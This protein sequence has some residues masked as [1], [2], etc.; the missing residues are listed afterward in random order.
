MD[1]LAI[2]PSELGDVSDFEVDGIQN[3]TENDVSDEEIEADELARRM[4]K[5]KVR[6]KRIKERQQKL[7]LQQA[8]LE[9]AKSKNISD[10]ALRKKI[11][12]A[13]DGILK[14]MLKLMEVCNARGFVYGIIPDKG[15]PVSGASDN[16]RA[17]WKEKVKFDKNGPAAIAKYEVENS[18]LFNTTSSG[19]T[20]EHSLMDLQDA[21]LGSL[22][23]ALMQHCSPQQRKYPLDKGIP[24][25][26]WPSG[27]EEWWIAL[28]LPKGKTPPYKKPHDLKKVWK[29]GV[30]TGVIKHM[31]PNF[32]KIRNY[33]LKSKCLQDKMTAKESLI[34][35]SVLQ[36][37]ENY[38]HSIDSGVS[39]ITHRYELG[40][41]N[42]NSYSSSDEYDVDCLEKPPHS[43]TSKDSVGAHQLALQIREDNVSS[44]GDRKH[45]DKQS[46]RALPS[47]KKTKESRKRKRRT[48]QFPVDESVVEVMQRNGDLPEVFSNAIPD[49]NRNQMEVPP[50][51]NRLTSVNNVSTSVA[52]PHQGH[53]EENF[54]SPGPVAIN[55]NCNQTTDATHSSVYI[56]EQPLACDSSDYRNPWPV[57]NFQQDLSLVP[58][59]FS[60]PPLDY[61]TSAAKQSLPLSMVP[62]MGT[63]ALVENTSYNHHMAA[64]GNSISVAGDAHQ[65]MSDD[66]YIDPDDKFVG[67]SFEGLPLDFIGINSPIPDLDELLDDDDLMQ[68]LG[69]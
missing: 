63:G 25:P 28:G 66:F 23:S 8:E 43:A 13:H 2:V 49:M 3:L 50:M 57:D 52:L 27:N 18:V 65:I 68:Y 26:W 53:A 61:H 9:N 32:G 48:G 56:G 64:S 37:E 10:L 15:K 39:E 51:A 41:K 46:T 17:W 30:L 1:H 22:L 31:A 33:V 44:R 12:R 69:T 42:G 5:D 38:I 58:I 20:N 14:Y 11:A 45:L 34:W 47:D 4:W 67:S 24:P 59:G 54:I 19:T 16:I 21:T 55:Y 60:S 62:T 36:R 6:F 7:A 35:L 40:D 29:V